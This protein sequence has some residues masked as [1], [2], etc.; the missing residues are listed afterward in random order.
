MIP[1]RRRLLAVAEMIPPS[2]GLVLDIGTDHAYLPIFLVQSGRAMHVIASDIAPLPLEKATRTVE[3]YGEHARVTL[4]LGDG[5]QDLAGCGA[6]AAVIAGMGGEMIIHILEQAVF[7]ANRNMRL[8]LQ[9]M[10][11]CEVLRRWLGENGF[12]IVNEKLVEDE[13]IYQVIEA[14]YDGMVRHL[15]LYQ[16]VVG[17]AHAD[18]ALFQEHLH[19]LIG[20]Y[21]ERIVGKQRAGL[22]VTEETA[23]VQAMQTALQEVSN[24]HLGV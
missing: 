15:S 9:P 4:H 10:T 5:M 13:K 18:R 3:K 8:I 1:L 17:S 19:R 6:D 23:L 22:S 21:T 20:V 14:R 12:A 24:E 7:A 11:R 16:C 2:T